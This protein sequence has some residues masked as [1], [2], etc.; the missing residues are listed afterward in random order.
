[1]SCVTSD[2]PI[3]EFISVYA[4]IISA[5]KKLTAIFLIGNHEILG[6]TVFNAGLQVRHTGKLVSAQSGRP[7]SPWQR[8]LVAGDGEG[9][10]S[11]WLARR[12]HHVTAVDNSRVGLDKASRLAA[13]NGVAVAL[14]E[15]DLEH[16]VPTPDS[17]DA[18]VLTYVHLPESWRHIAHQRLTSA[19]RPGGCFILE[20]FHPLQLGYSSGGPKDESLLY[21]IDM[22][23]S[24]LAAQPEV[25]L[26]E[27]LAW[28]GEAHLDEGSGHQGSA[29]LT[30]YVAHRVKSRNPDTNA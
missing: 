3:G 10:N 22:I 5:V 6:S 24:D 4:Y 9:R 18:V 17:F 28:E 15:A 1:M 27:V 16:W 23:R 29:H 7:P 25:I 30:R 8:S 19:L 12:G 21:T 13:E 14:I 26:D 11:V 20:A 2:N